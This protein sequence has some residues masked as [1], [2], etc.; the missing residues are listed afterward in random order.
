MLSA[1]LKYRNVN[2]YETGPGFS[3]QIDE[4]FCIIHFN[5]LVY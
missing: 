1:E 2:T 5:K 4:Y 3:K